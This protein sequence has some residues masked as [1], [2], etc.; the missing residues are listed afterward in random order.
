ML[1]EQ[2]AKEIT[3]FVVK[4]LLSALTTFVFFVVMSGVTMY[5]G[6]QINA[7]ILHFGTGMVFSNIWGM[8]NDAIKR[9]RLKDN[10]KL[11]E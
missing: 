5:F 3:Y 2:N 10:G 1:N 4:A 6:H 8:F 9:R 7:N 11:P